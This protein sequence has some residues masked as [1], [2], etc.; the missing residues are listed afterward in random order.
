MFKH[1][2]EI[3]E[4][5]DIYPIFSLLV[6]L[7][8]FSMTIVF[9]LKSDKEYIKEMSNLPLEGDDQNEK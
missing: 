2:F 4:G 8:F 3:I 6:F 5:I 7:I 9:I 1:Y